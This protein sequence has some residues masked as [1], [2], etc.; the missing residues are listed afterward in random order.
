[1]RTFLHRFTS[2]AVL[3]MFVVSYASADDHLSNKWRLEFS[4]NAES[5]GTIVIEV[6]PEGGETIRAEIQVAMDRSEN[7]VAK[8]VV[9]VLEAL[10]PEETYNVERDDGEDVL[11]KKRMGEE[12]FA[13]RIISNSVQGVRIELEKE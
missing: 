3:L 6:Q 12:N 7:E 1:M 11:V 10:L 4:G 9:T 5:S 13:L 2:A 8:R